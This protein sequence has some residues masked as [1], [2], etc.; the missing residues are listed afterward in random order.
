MTPSRPPLVDAGCEGML[1][2]RR[3]ETKRPR[4]QELAAAHAKI[5]QMRGSERL[6][7]GSRD[8]PIVRKP[9]AS[10]EPRP[11]RAA[12]PRAERTIDGASG[13]RSRL[14]FGACR[15][16]LAARL[17]DSHPPRRIEAPRGGRAR[18]QGHGMGSGPRASETA[19]AM[20]LQSRRR[21]QQKQRESSIGRHPERSH[22]CSH[23]PPAALSRCMRVGAAQV[24]GMGRQGLGSPCQ[25]CLCFSTAPCRR[26]R[27]LA[28][29]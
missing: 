27:L 16:R 23:R 29:F 10:S 8:R 6:R 14:R 24:G 2:A 9:A 13:L 28:H 18:E 15:A 5:D 20:R 25:Q 19:A 7:S 12:T 21:L 22:R 26:M 1:L 17:R 11:N 4:L 3:A